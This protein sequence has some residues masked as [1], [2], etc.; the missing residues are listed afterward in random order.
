MQRPVHHIMICS[1]SRFNGEPKG[2]C[3]NKNAAELIQY[4]EEA[5]SERGMD[6]V[7]V[8]NTGC[9][10]LCDRG[11]I[12]VI[13]PEGYWYGG[14]DQAAIDRILDALSTGGSVKE[15]LLT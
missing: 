2:I 8:T 3:R 13:Y 10:K 15:L 5:L 1:S 11:P 7:L 14:V 12:M 6:Q 9:M 4:L